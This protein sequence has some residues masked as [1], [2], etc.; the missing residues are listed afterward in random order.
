MPFS[1]FNFKPLVS[2][3]EGYLIN[4]KFKQVNQ[5]SFKKAVIATWATLVIFLF[6]LVYTFYFFLTSANDI[7]KNLSNVAVVLI[8]LVFFLLMKYAKNVYYSLIFINF[9]VLPVLY[10]SIFDS[11]GLESPDMG[12]LLFTVITCTFF[13]N[14]VFGL[15]VSS[16]TSGFLVFLYSNSD[17]QTHPNLQN[18][19]FSWLFLILL[20]TA[21]VNTFT[22][23]LDQINNR[24][25]QLSANRIEELDSSLK[26][27]IARYASLRTDL[28]KDFHDEM[29]NKLATIKLLSE[30]LE[31]KMAVTNKEEIHK[32]LSDIQ[33]NA[34]ELLEGTRDFLW[35]IDWNNNAISEFVEYVEQFA[36]NLLFKFNIRFQSKHS[37]LDLVK[38]R[39]FSPKFFRQMI[40]VCKEV[41]T[42]TIKHSNAENFKFE[43]FISENK[44]Q[45]ILS[46]DGCGFDIEQLKRTSGIANIKNRVEKLG[47]E[48]WIESLNG[49]KYIIE[50]QLSHYFITQ[51]G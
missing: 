3:V 15:I 6:F 34:K 39:V 20:V 19:F 12:W 24:L 21:V 38:N 2:F 5:L 22:F 17:L 51:N 25:L 45:M 7:N 8:L 47:G 27:S 50:I 37:G 46:D 48:I 31:T 9:T 36:E 41:I 43:L 40:F 26:L 30:S 32:D 42:N 16:L 23:L 44:F 14:R 13:V 33:H 1:A 10:K 49:T 11:G 28:G 29:G 35:S 18:V 4:Q